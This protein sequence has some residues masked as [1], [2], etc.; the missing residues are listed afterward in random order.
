MVAAPSGA[1]KTSLVNQ[2]I[3]RLDDIKI[4]ISYTTR[5]PR[6]KEVDGVEYHF[7][8]EP[9]FLQMIKNDIFLEHAVVYGHHYGTSKTWVSK[10]LEKGVDVILEIDWQGAALIRSRF[11][12]AVT[13]FVLPPS[14]QV[15]RERLEKRQQDSDRVID[16]RMA[17]ARSEITHYQ[18][19]E[20]L[21]V[22]DDF[23]QTLE[24]LKDIVCAERLRCRVQRTKLDSL[25]ADLL[26]K[27]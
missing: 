2:L 11:R 9:A 20:Y 12:R 18:E 21:L 23:E 22:N 1:G 25:L 6:P 3:T 27:Q 26:R 16:D 19:F 17:Q 7:V 24:D 13:I 8:D 15:L 5:A 14:T 10:Q 4:S